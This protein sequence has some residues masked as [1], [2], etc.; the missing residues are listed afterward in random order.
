MVLLVHG[1][2]LRP[3]QMRWVIEQVTA[4][5]FDVIT[6]SLRGHG[7]NYTPL[8]GKSARAARMASFT[9]L[10]YAV[11]MA[12]LYA[13]YRV[14][15]THSQRV[16]RPLHFL[17]FSLGGLLLCNLLA[18]CADVAID[19]M[20]LLAPALKVRTLNHVIKLFFPIPGLRVP[21]LAPPRYQANWAMTTSG[22]RAT[23]AAL[24]HLAQQLEQNESATQRLNIPTQVFMHK[25]DEMVSY[26]GIRRLVERHELT[27]WSIQAVPKG[28]DARVL[29]HHPMFDPV[30]VGESTWHGMMQQAVAHLRDHA[31]Q[32]HDVAVGKGHDGDQTD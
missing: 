32:P 13:A 29:L 3:S 24:E 12:E 18:S 20:V 2:N 11:W 1:L 30:A 19:R 27:N 25:W 10:S 9:E 31:H 23:F 7:D 22:Y 21:S 6:L 8:S 28:P 4:A 26:R 14:A 15:A 5:H 16:D 17:G